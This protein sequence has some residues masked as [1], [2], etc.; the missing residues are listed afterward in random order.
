MHIEA[1]LL[2]ILDIVHG[3]LEERLLLRRGYI[4]AIAYYVPIREWILDCGTF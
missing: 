4:R 3:R 1:I 2:C